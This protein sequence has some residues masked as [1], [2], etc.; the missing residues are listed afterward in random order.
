M[1]RF[2]ACGSMGE[3]V[4]GARRR[5]RR[6]HSHNPT[7]TITEM[8]PATPTFCLGVA[9]LTRV[10]PKFDPPVLHQC[11][12]HGRTTAFQLAHVTHVAS[13]HIVALGRLK[14]HAQFRAVRVRVK[15]GGDN[16]R[17]AVKSPQFAASGTEGAVIAFQE[18]ITASET[19]RSGYCSARSVDTPRCICGH[20]WIWHRA[21][22][23]M[24]CEYGDCACLGFA[25]AAAGKDVVRREH[26]KKR[27]RAP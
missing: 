12:A 26:R 2:F 14:E 19:A 3:A 27:P 11:L 16:A 8:A 13:Q 18:M 23:P 7:P 15:M 5:P 17:G 25:T 22:D 6:L 10:C 1:P 21:D 4:A 24:R 20:S 9:E